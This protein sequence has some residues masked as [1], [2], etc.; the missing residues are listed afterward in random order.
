M[1]GGIRQNLGLKALAVAAIGL[2]LMRR[3]QPFGGAYKPAV[4]MSALGIISNTMG[5]GNADLI[6]A[7]IKYGIATAVDQY[8]LG[9][10]LGGLGGGNAQTGGGL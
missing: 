3:F 10:L 5:A 1:F 6:S 2:P 4:D 7:G 8:L 9:G